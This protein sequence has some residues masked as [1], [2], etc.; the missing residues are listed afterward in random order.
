MRG[1]GVGMHE[2]EGTNAGVVI[3]F[4][5]IVLLGPSVRCSEETDACT[6]SLM[7]FKAMVMAIIRWIYTVCLNKY[8]PAP[9][10]LGMNICS[11]DNILF[12]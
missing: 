9:T 10:T 2:V 12:D 5:D 8:F 11:F 4:G 7:Y 1:N 3:L 6:V